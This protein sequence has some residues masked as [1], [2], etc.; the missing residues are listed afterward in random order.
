MGLIRFYKFHY[1]SNCFWYKLLNEK[2]QEKKIY[3]QIT[4]TLKSCIIIVLAVIANTR[5]TD[6]VSAASVLGAVL[7][8]KVAFS[9]ASLY[10]RVILPL[11]IKDLGIAC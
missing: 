3:S 2:V 7:E 1:T 8:S 10:I 6:S 4:K 11:V 9:V 5:A